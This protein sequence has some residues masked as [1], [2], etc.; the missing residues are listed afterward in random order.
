MLRIVLITFLLVTGALI[1][2]AS[3][4]DTLTSVLKNV[5]AFFSVSTKPSIITRSRPT[6]KNDKPSDTTVSEPILKIETGFHSAIVNKISLTRNGQLVSVSDDKTARLWTAIDEPSKVLRVPIGPQSEGA[7]YAIA[8]SPTKDIAAVGGSTGMSWDG[9]ATIYFIDLN[10]GEIVGSIPG[11]PSTI[12]ALNYSKDGKYLA[13]GTNTG[14]LSVIDKAAKSLAT[15]NN[16]CSGSI[17]AIEYMADNRFITACFDGSVRVYDQKFQ[18]IAKHI[19]ANKQRPWR[20]AISPDQTQAA[21]GTLDANEIEVVS[22]KDLTLSNKF[23]SREKT[24]GAFS[25]VAWFG[26]TLFGAGTYGDPSGNKYIHSWNLKTGKQSDLAVAKDS[27]TDLLPFNNNE[28]AYATAEGLIGKVS[29]DNQGIVA[30]PRLIPDYRNA[31]EG[32]F[33]LSKD[34]T[35]LEIGKAQGGKQPVKFSFL[36]RALA[37]NP[38]PDKGLFSPIIPT[39]AKNWRDSMQPTLNGKPIILGDNEYSR[40]IA[41][42]DDGTLVVIGADYSLGLFKNGESLWNIPQQ[43]PTLAV[44]LTRDGRYVVAALGDGTVHWLNVNDASEAMALFITA[45]NRWVAWTPDGYF[46][47]STEIAPHRQEN[48]VRRGLRPVVQSHTMASSFVGYHINRGHTA[49]PT[50]V[51]SDQ[52]QRNFY[53]PDLVS[54]TLYSASILT[55]EINREDAKTVVSKYLPPMLKSLAWCDD[56]QCNDVNLAE[57]N[58]IN[59]KVPEIKLRYEF[60]DQGSGIGNIVLKRSGATVATRGL[61]VSN[62]IKGPYRD[63]QKI[64]LESGDNPITLSAFDVNKSLQSNEQIN[65]VIHYDAVSESKPSLY[66]L[67]IGINKYQSTGINAL[68]NA[69]ND[70]EGINS[71]LQNQHNRFKEVIPKLLADEQ[72]TRKNIEDNLKT[73]SSK[74]QPNDVVVIYIAGHGTVINGHYYF[75]PYELK[76]TVNDD[77][78]ANALSDATLSELISNFHTLRVAVLIDSCYAGK[79]ASSDMVMRRNQDATWTG[80]LGQSTGRFVLAGSANDQEALDGKDGHGVFTAVLLDALNGKA[81]LELL[82]NKDNRVNVMELSAYA[83]QHVSEE[84]KKIDPSHSQEATWFFMGS[85][86]FELADV[87][88]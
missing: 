17:T 68:V 10:T 23:S 81:D 51:S 7:L 39:N 48:V 28:L 65:L 8:T 60:T 67:S 32:K 44:N 88:S 53:R 76:T 69:V 72:A 42:S 30:Q 86:I 55:D 78:Q 50:F 20:I 57:S 29:L 58:T 71:L 35:V 46:D 3:S 13:V 87:K 38:E 31:Y 6:P 34:G 36:E 82:G 70:A 22:L 56:K 52:I 25:S 45:D 80:A 73:I 16:D 77:I 47:H 4:T 63:E 21:I 84:A 37:E 61:R 62:A 85:D 75:I 43:S 14:V 24:H 83:K 15:Q 41:S 49:T 27:I 33:A 59:V 19:L 66:V 1:I 9:T 5:E 12:H 79:L 54:Q 40:S 74:A 2:W 64:F 18:L 26:D 11:I